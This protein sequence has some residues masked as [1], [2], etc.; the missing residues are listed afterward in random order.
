MKHLI[1]ETMSLEG[2]RAL[3]TGANGTLGKQISFALAE[4]G[5]DLVLHDLPDTNYEVLI[6]SIAK[7]N[8]KVSIETIDFDLE[9]ESSR[10]SLIQQLILDKRP[11]NILVNNAALVGTSELKGWNEDFHDQSIETWRKAFEVNLTSVFHI[12]QGL[13][14]KISESHN[15]SII[16]IGSIYG[17][18][19]P[20]YSIYEN[21]NIN[22]PSAYSVSKAGL[23]HL[24]K[25]LASTLSPNIRVNSISPGGIQYKGMPENFIEAYNRKVPMNRMG[26]KEDIKGAIIF[27]ASD[28][29]SYVTG[30][31]IM[32]DGGWTVL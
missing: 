32:I 30:Q 24:T 20:D 5:A 26:V 25:W 1:K 8:K 23:I 27:L 18:V 16:N 9:N 14:S 4:L 10:D 3:I 21:T 13:S 17:V 15:S 6:Q 31:N 11:L 28:L 7:I 2:R 22:N 19:G 29:S 12:T